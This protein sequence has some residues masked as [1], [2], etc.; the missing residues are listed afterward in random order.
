MLKEILQERSITTY[1]LA[2]DIGEPYSTINDIVNGKVNISDCKSRIL[3]E[4]SEYLGQTMEETYQQCSTEI[5]IYS[6][7]YG[8]SGTVAVKLKRYHLHFKYGEK[9]YNVEISKV[10]EGSTMFVKEAALY[11]MERIIKSEKLEEYLCSMK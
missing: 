4:I 1:K 7:E 11:E 9:E 2:K 6:G 10:T 3:K 5:K 8:I